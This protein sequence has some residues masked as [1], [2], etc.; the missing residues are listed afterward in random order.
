MAFFD[1]LGKK[2]S[3]A[4]QTAI[5][6]T[7]DMT[8]IA[9]INGLIS[10]E[11][12]KVNNT[13]YQIGKLYVATYQNDFE[14]DFAGMITTI[15]ESE[16]KIANYKQQVLD[17]K[18]VTHCEKCGAE[19]SCNMAFCSSCGAPMPKQNNDVSSN[20]DLIK[21]TGCGEMV[22][23][24]MRFC[25]SCGKPIADIL[26]TTDPTPPAADEPTAEASADKCPNCGATIDKDSAFCTECG[27][28][29]IQ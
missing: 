15:R 7:K 18:G 5:Q 11:E 8:D 26:Q 25:T 4:G 29:L 20:A 10:D 13:Y 21:C 3:Q 12:K 17:I 23:K 9:R 16:E 2:L 22:N 1:N 19:V 28:K 24:N 14:S 6:K 27:T